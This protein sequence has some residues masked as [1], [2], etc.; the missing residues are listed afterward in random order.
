M[1]IRE[2]AHLR[3]CAFAK[4]RIREGAH[5]R[6]CA[7]AKMRIREDAHSRRCAFAKMRIREDAHSRRVVEAPRCA[8]GCFVSWRVLSHAVSIPRRLRRACSIGACSRTRPSCPPAVLGACSV[9]RTI[10]HT[11]VKPRR[12]RRGCRS[13]R[14]VS[15]A[16]H[17]SQ[18]VC[19]QTAAAHPTNSYTIQRMSVIQCPIQALRKRV[20]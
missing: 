6:R 1:R 3:R 15:P 11:V 12:K 13:R 5:L 9:R 16:H 20:A 18:G 19:S 10:A 14:G 4:M 7:F 8:G 17:P 2:D